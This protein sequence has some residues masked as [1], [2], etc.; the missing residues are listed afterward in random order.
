M[1]PQQYERLTELF[2]A[3][4]EIA[5]D[6]RA[7]FL[8]QVCDGDVDLR[9][10]LESMLA[11]H[12]Q[13]AAYTEKPLDD[14]AAGYVA[15]QGGSSASLPSLTRNTRIDHYEIRSLLGK[16]GMGEV[17]LAEDT[18]LHRKVALKILPA[19]IAT[20]QDRMRRFELEATTAAALNHP[21]IAHIY[22]IGESAGTHFIAIEY[23]DGDTLRDKIHRDKAPLQKLLKYLIQVA[24]GL[25][26]A[27]SA[28]IVHRDLKPDNIM[29]TRD[30]HAKIL[31]FG[32]AKLI[33]PRSPLG[34]LGSASAS[35]AGTGIM[36]HQ[37]LAGMV[38]GTVGY[39]SPEQALG[40]VKEIDQRSDIFSFGCILFEAVTG[41]TPFADKSVIKSL[42]KVVYEAAPPIKDFNPSTPADL[43]RVIRRCLAK[44]PEERYQTIKD[45]LIDLRELRQELDSEA[46]PERSTEQESRNGAPGNE[47]DSGAGP[48]EIE[49]ASLQTVR[50]GDEFATGTMSNTR[51]GTVGI[52]RHRR[53][54]LLALG[55]LALVVAGVVLGIK[56]IGW[57]RFET[58]SSEPFTRIKLARLT[59]NGKAS[60]AAIS[61]E[62]K[63]LVH[64]MGSAGQQSLWLRHI[65][66]GSDKEIVPTT[67][68]DI[69]GAT[70]SHDGNYLYFT[71]Q[72][73]LDSVL[74]QVPVLGG[75]AKRS[76]ADI[77]T[78]ITLSPDDKRFA[79]IR[80]YP[81]YGETALM[82][83]NADGT[84]EQKL[85][86]HKPRDFNSFVKPTWSPGGE[87][88]AA[89]SRKPEAEGSFRT[90]ITVRV[91][92]GAEKVITSQRW[93]DIVAIAWL[94]DGSG[95][96]VSAADEESGPANQVWHVAYPTGEA[97]R[98]TNDTN[99]YRGI[100]LTADSSSFVTVQT[101]TISN[102]WVAPD[103]NVSRAT[104]VSSNKNDGSE[105]LAWIPDGRIVFQSRASGNNDLWVT[106]ADGTNQKQLTTEAGNDIW[107]A[108][109]PDG[110]YI[111]FVSNRVEGRD[112]IWR[113]RTDGT[114]PRPLTVGELKLSQPASDNQ[115]VFFTS[116]I[117]GKASLMRVSVNGGTPAQLT[118][119]AAA[120]P[121]L[122][123]DG[124]QL[125]CGFVDTQTSTYRIGILGL[126]GGAPVK[127]LDL[128]IPSRYQP[129][130]W[131][132][133]GRALAYIDTRAGVSNLWRLPLDGSKR[134]Q[135]TDFKTDQIF[136]FDW[137]RDG[138]WLALARGSVTSDVVLVRDS[139]Q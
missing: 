138:R 43:Q 15:Q 52:R 113:M 47:G 12:E 78:V 71:R 21:H 41:Q 111:L 7:A 25:T 50:T 91:T 72:D 8:A 55:G 79:F 5:P 44:D 135:I 13:R 105:G 68:G 48:G 98:L 122:S 37:S 76:G 57:N 94:T 45:L 20:D 99:D 64:V 4:L 129:L 133:D 106:N 6:E 2:H 17:Y 74:Y 39:M 103:R 90:I 87:M 121:L 85:V 66:T 124:T 92:D 59:T 26:K 62:G 104:Q 95:L 86:A 65:A 36:A 10:E 73:A 88:I 34:S 127:V 61:P 63:Y 56:Y 137:S 107:P 3:A 33:E 1:T 19:A 84:G 9:R 11:A 22:E 136:Q 70:F 112:S 119:Y 14:I 18:R 83:A 93:T 139:R 23:I 134:K 27:H 102:I 67:G 40:K 126:E 97:R 53:G 24:E 109:T 31:D 110:R 96:I 46:K 82:L 128:Q 49:T 120:G 132:P 101:E 125:A 75:A 108:V 69:L 42:H 60:Q 54:V 115:S 29:I 123:P 116:S 118:D 81:E 100:S 30:D 28:G 38:M 89:A 16:G 51:I 80:G 117:N 35:E 131:T 32:L 77:D 130:R 114:D 58:K